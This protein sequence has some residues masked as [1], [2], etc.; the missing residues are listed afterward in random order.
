MNTNEETNINKN[1]TFNE[2]KH[3]VEGYLEIIKNRNKTF[4]SK[5]ENN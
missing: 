2:K 5:N 4:V 1:L 3:I